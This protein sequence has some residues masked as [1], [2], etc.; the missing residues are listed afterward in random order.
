[1]EKIT[2]LLPRSFN[3]RAAGLNA[4][5][6]DV[7][8]EL[9]SEI[10]K[11]LV[12][13]GDSYEEISGMEATLSL[14]WFTPGWMYFGHIGDCRIYYLSA[15]DGT[16]KQL[17]HDDTHVG[18]LYRNG[19]LNER[20]ARTH[21]RRTVLQK[22]LG[23]GNQFVEPQVGSVGY[24]PG[25][26]FLLCSDGLIDGLY[27]SHLADNLRELKTLKPGQNP[28]QRLVEQSL[29]QSGKDNT[30]ALIVQVV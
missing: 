17:S 16:F 5:F 7:L 30:T 13:V 27:D 25:D 3:Q 9:F 2:T 19:Q 12:Y 10:H 20:E 28:A 22:S 24:E 23:G 21:P 11:A 18:W 6:P 26:A 8:N 1:V 29:T 15:R 4:G 14:C